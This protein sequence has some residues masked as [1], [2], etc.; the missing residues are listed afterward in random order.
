VDNLG[1]M[2]ANPPEATAEPPDG[3]DTTRR[4]GWFRRWWWVVLTG[5][6]VVTAMSV[7]TWSVVAKSKYVIESPGDLTA[8]GDLIHVNGTQTF[9][10][11][12]RINLVTVNVDSDPSKLQEFFAEH[13][14]DSELIK[15]QDVLGDQTP[16]QDNAL[17]TVLMRQ[18]KDTAVLVA[19]DRLGYNVD[20]TTTGALVMQVTD[21]APVTGKLDIGDTIVAVNGAPV[22]SSDALRMVLAQYKPGDTITVGIENSNNV[23][24]DEQ[25][26]LGSSP[27]P[28]RQGAAYLG[29]LLNDRL[30]YQLPNFDVTVNS[31]QIGG[32]SAGL[33]FTLG[34]IDALTPGDLTGGQAIAATGE[35]HPDG[36]VA[37]IGGVD[38]K[39]KTVGRGGVKT[40]FVP[41]DNADEARA[42]APSGV[43]VV[44]VAT[45]DDALN[46]LAAHGGTPIPARSA[47]GT[48]TK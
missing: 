5:V 24:R 32:P 7:L 31:N 3:G 14:S 37:A 1:T 47:T 29:V 26:T 34:I 19:L 10:T 16:Q 45:L 44:P 30:K 12:D 2:V 46:Y 41:V 33:A 4:K 23:R 15:K 35:I 43:T 39:V 20:P 48:S 25:I 42:N 8:T 11:N 40:F 38:K 13:D 17:N 18:S 6:V 28:Q 22:T 21:G 9:P 36:S 27:D